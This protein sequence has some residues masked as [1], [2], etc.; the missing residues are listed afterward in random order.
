MEEERMLDVVPAH[1]CTTR[2]ERGSRAAVARHDPPPAVTQLQDPRALQTLLDHLP[3]G[4][5]IVYGPPSFPVIAS[6][7]RLEELTGVHGDDLAR[8]LSGMEPRRLFLSDGLRRPLARELPLHRASRFGEEIRNEEL[9]LVRPDGTRIDILVDAN[10]IR[11]KTGGIVGAITCWR[12]VTDLKRS[13]DAM[14]KVEAQLRDADLRKDEFLGIL[15][16]ELR[17]P[18][19]P[20]RN[21]VQLLKAMASDEPRLHHIGDILDRQV[22]AVARLLDDLLDLSR[23][24]RGNLSLRMEPVELF[25]VIDQAVEWNRAVIDS[26]GQQ[27]TVIRPPTPMIVIGDPVRLAQ[28]VSNLVGNAAKFT[29]AGG[30]IRIS[31]EI[32]NAQALVR[33]RD[34]GPGLEPSELKNIFDLFF[35][36]ERTADR[37]GRGLGIGLSLVRRLVEM[38]GGQVQAFSEGRG[39]GSEFVFGLPLFAKTT[40]VSQTA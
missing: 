22:T 7:R 23:V 40:G 27:L 36:L 29:D 12:D 10:P 30:S 20:I 11:T 31:A 13:R 17:G 9:V 21:A 19:S 35:Q 6:S 25:A 14:Q 34:T 3:E 38:H 24:R 18:L 33:V 1:S 4:V 16:H 26:K 39:S 2:S 32:V 37:T 15:A 28:V 8:L 5:A